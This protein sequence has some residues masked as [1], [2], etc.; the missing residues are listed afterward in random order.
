MRNPARTGQEVYI[1]TTDLLPRRDRDNRG[2]SDFVPGERVIIVGMIQGQMLVVSAERSA[3]VKPNQ[4]QE[5][6]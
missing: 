1:A 4:L 2:N 5:I 6:E 3:W